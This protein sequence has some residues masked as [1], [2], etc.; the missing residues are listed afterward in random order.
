MRTARFEGRDPELVVCQY[1]GKKCGVRSG[2][3]NKGKGKE[4]RVAMEDEQEHHPESTEEGM[5]EF[6]NER[7]RESLSR[8]S[9]IFFFAGTDSSIFF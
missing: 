3:K 8:S 2:R 4:V 7:L 1:G 9:G 6:A 5:A